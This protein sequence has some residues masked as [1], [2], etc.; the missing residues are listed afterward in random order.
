MHKGWNLLNIPPG[1][2]GS[3]DSVMGVLASIDGCYDWV[4]EVG[5][6]KNYHYGEGGNTLTEMDAGTWYWVNMTVDARFF[7]NTDLIEFP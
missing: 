2:I 7:T 3:D 1:G 4:F 5:T 6:W